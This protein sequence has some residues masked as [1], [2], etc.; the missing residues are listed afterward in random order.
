MSDV[1]GAWPSWATKIA[2]G[3]VAVL[4]GAAVVAAAFVGVLAGLFNATSR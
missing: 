2:V 4:A 1:M 3:A